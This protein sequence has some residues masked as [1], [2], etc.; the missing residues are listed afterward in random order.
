MQEIFREILAEIRVQPL[1]SIAKAELIAAL[2]DLEGCVGFHR[3][4]EVQILNAA[5]RLVRA[6]NPREGE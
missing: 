2:G 3:V 4:E 5:M 6:A 1:P